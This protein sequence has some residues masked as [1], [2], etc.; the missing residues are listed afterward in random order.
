MM[1]EIIYGRRAVEECLLADRRRVF[2]VFTS[3]RTRLSAQSA[4]RQATERRG[5]SINFVPKDRLEQMVGRVNHQ[6][7]VA[8][9]SPYPYW[10]MQDVLNESR[11]E[12]NPILLLLD[13]LQDPQNLGALIRSAEAVGVAGVILPRNRSVSVT[14]AVVN[15]S[16]GAVE[17]VKVAIV[18]NLVRA[19]GDLKHAGFWLVGLEDEHSAQRYD[20]ADLNRPVGSVIGSEGQG[21][22]RLVKETCDYLV[23]IPMTG[24]VASLNAS[25]AGSIVLYEAWRQRDTGLRVS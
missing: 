7:V 5:I 15:A 4:L 12:A 25:I 1:R 17:H 16:A 23:R 10:E 21:L 20:Q 14:P 9:T 24:R 19:M 6:G 18:T 3:E 8:E 11:G 22:G 13:C 2:A